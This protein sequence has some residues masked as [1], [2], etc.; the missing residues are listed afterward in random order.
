[1]ALYSLAHYSLA[2]SRVRS[3][4]TTATYTVFCQLMV[5]LFS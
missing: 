3:D 2:H 4:S 5:N 1:M